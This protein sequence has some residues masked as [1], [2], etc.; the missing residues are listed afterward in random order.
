MWGDPLPPCQ[1]VLNQ[2]RG[3]KTSESSQCTDLPSLRK[4]IFDFSWGVGGYTSY[5]WHTV[6]PNLSLV[7]LPP[8]KENS[9]EQNF[10]PSGLACMAGVWKGREWE[11]KAREK[12]EGRGARG[13]RLG[14]ACQETIVFAIPPSNYVCKNNTTVN[15]LLSNKS[16]HDTLIFG[17]CF[18]KTR[19]L[20]WR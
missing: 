1:Q 4:N 15:D 12:R 6:Y 13:G 10:Y 14:N 5:R 3:L 19:N 2:G 17:F 9:L 16:G 7:P 8:W 18:P 20:K 11:F